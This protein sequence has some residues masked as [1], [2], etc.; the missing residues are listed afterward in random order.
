MDKS[1]IKNICIDDFA[2]KKRYSYGTVMVDLDTHKIIDIIATRETTAVA[3]WLK[4]YPNLEVVSRDGAQTYSSAAT[5]ACPNAIQV[6]DRF[7]LL[8]NLSEATERYMRRLFPSRLEIPVTVSSTTPEM[9]ALYNT[10][11]RGQ[12]IRFAQAKRKEGYT[13]N[14]IALLLHA[15]TTTIQRYLSISPDNIPDDLGSARERQHQKDIHR[16]QAAIKQ[17]KELYELGHCISE[18]SRLTGHTPNTVKKYL[19][20]D[21]SLGHAKYDTRTPGKLAPYEQT[22]IEMRSQGI[23]YPKIHSFICEK[24][25]I[26]SVASLRMFMQKEREHQK[27]V[28]PLNSEHKEY[29]PRKFMCQLIYRKLEDVKGINQEQ[30]EGVL[31]TYPILGKLYSLLRE[32]Q[33]IVFSQKC[34][35]LIT[36]IKSAEVLDIDEITTYTNGLKNDIEA[37][38]NS[39]K[40]KF[41]N[42][43]A[44][45]SVNKIKLIKR[46][47]YGRNSFELLKAKVL[48][49]E[50]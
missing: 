32:F 27:S 50:L 10:R 12:R 30:Y 44:E 46:I 42:G 37:V 43:L 21:C 47:M 13:V 15:G 6:S 14:D 48:L 5:N 23:S 26:G 19:K 2:F 38:E 40:Y 36:W 41:N 24:G 45:G 3:T 9:Q 11:N 7:H 1:T 22:V 4:T 34:E 16:K 49:N 35:E 31:K 28:A 8:K 39:I 33:R 20:P 29:I 25:Y 18:I 17:V